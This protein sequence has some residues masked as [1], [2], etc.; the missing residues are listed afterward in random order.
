MV[1]SGL[2]SILTKSI[3]VKTKERQKLEKRAKKAG[4]LGPGHLRGLSL[5]LF[6]NIK[7]DTT[8]T[9]KRILESVPLTRGKYA[10]FSFFISMPELPPWCPWSGA[11]GFPRACSGLSHFSP[12]FCCTPWYTPGSSLGLCLLRCSLRCRG[13]SCFFTVCRSRGAVGTAPLSQSHCSCMSHSAPPHCRPP[14][15]SALCTEAISACSP[16]VV[17]HH[18][19]DEVHVQRFIPAPLSRLLPTPNPA[20]NLWHP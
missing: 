18:M 2:L 10:L 13:W 15:R 4:C 12:L 11:L 9:L 14:G 5:V 19:Q 8:S 1:T 3:L 7:L 6:L 20:D 17:S 16:S